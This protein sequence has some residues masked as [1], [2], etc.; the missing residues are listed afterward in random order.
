[1][2]VVIPE[3][4]SGTHI[5]TRETYDSPYCACAIG[6]LDISRQEGPHGSFQEQAA[7]YQRSLLSC[8]IWPMDDDSPV[9]NILNAHGVD[10]NLVSNWNDFVCQTNAER[11]QALRN[12]CE[13]CE[14]PYIEERDDRPGRVARV[15][16]EERALEAVCA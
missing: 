7:D 8:E 9:F 5:T 15:D 6:A 11:R 14:I 4:M 3:R 16:V 12:L 10:G 2:L 1:M 13:Y